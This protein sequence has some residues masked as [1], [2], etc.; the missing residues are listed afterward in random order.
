MDK[1][2]LKTT[3]SHEKQGLKKH[4]L[5]FQALS[6]HLFK[7]LMFCFFQVIQEITSGVNSHTSLHLAPQMVHMN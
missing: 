1:K 4:F 3:T 6:H 7:L 5:H 2:D